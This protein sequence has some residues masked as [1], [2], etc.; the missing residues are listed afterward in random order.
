LPHPVTL[1]W[2]HDGLRPLT[3]TER[4][5]DRTGQREIDS[6][7]FAIVTDLVGTPTELLDE[8]GDIAWRTRTTLWGTTTWN[9]DATTY[10]PLRFPG[11]YHDPETALHYNF[12]RHYD[13]TTARYLSPDPLGLAPDPNPHT[14]VENPFGWIDPLGL[15]CIPY[16][17]ATEKVQ[18]VLDR[19]RDKGSPPAGYKGGRMFENTGAH[20][21]QRLPDTDPAGNPIAYREWDVNPKVK[22]VDRGEERLV[23]GSDG[24]A[25]Y[26][27]DHYL[28]FIQV[29]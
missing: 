18:N 24:S 13:P 6:R 27:T 1:T 9:A 17:P 28:S 4:I 11:Q 25:Y 29:P 23:T 26:T 16:G 15:S 7:F 19:V 2:D 8:Q 21:A 10:T 12:H 14:Y 20:G 5:T 3:Q 22:G